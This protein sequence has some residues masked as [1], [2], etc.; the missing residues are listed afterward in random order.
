MLILGLSGRIRP[1]RQSVSILAGGRPALPW[2]ADLADPL[3]NLKEE[4]PPDLC[5]FQRL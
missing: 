1:I 5:R 4:F 3:T 2:A